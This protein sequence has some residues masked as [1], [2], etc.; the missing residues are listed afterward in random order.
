MNKQH[1]R[2][3]GTDK[4]P[5]FSLLEVEPPL[6]KARGGGGEGG[7]LDVP[8]SPPTQSDC[9]GQR[10]DV[11]FISISIRRRRFLCCVTRFELHL[12]LLLNLSEDNE[13]TYLYL[14]MM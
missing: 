9:E 5:F 13:E 7:G 12:L 3:S 1:D 6:R 10:R 2:V 4:V 14:S 8:F 11:P